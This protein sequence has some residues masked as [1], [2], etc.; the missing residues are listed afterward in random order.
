NPKKHSDC[1]NI[2]TRSGKKLSKTT[3]TGVEQVEEL[4]SEIVLVDEDEAEK[5]NSTKRIEPVVT[6]NSQRVNGKGKE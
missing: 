4:D 6:E 1:M 2:T 3:P 5:L